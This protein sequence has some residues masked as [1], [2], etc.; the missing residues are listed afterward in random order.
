MIAAANTLWAAI[1]QVP[2]DSDQ[3]SDPTCLLELPFPFPGA[4][5]PTDRFDFHDCPPRIR[6]FTYMGRVGFHRILHELP[7]PPVYVD[8]AVAATF[9]ASATTAAST[10]SATAAGSSA[11]TAEY[12][13][14][15]PSMPHFFPP[16]RAD[17]HKSYEMFLYG[18][19]GWGKQASHWRHRQT[20]CA[21]Y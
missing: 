21:A 17:R 5:K 11:I 14:Q 4:K 20:V 19:I 13:H 16:I 15:P 8:D 1:Q 6:T 18:T 2:A 7:I 10:A 12:L 9:A 3:Y